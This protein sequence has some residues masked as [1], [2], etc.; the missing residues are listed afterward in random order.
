MN[1]TMQ[2]VHITQSNWNSVLQRINRPDIDHH[3]L[4]LHDLTSILS[5]P[6]LKLL[7]LAKESFKNENFFTD[8]HIRTKHSIDTKTFAFEG[9]CPAYHSSATCPKLSANYSNLLIPVEVK[10]KGDSEIRKFRHF[11][12]E[13]RY[14]IDTDESLFLT[15]LEAQFFLKNPIKKV[16]HNNSGSLETNNLDLDTVKKKIDMLLRDAEKFRS[17]D[18]GTRETIE[19]LGYGTHRRAEAKMRGHV[20]YIWH[21]E[22]KRNLKIYLQTYFRIRFNP[23]LV[24][25]GDLLGEL[26]FQPCSYCHS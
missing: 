7:A 8:K 15:R 22:Y 3:N 16:H 11:C 6:E 10:E 18:K 21:N 1:N 14:L 23:E 26:G 12:K 13:N 2:V 25:R 17:R 24:F 5:I 9:G 19:K 20:L 4:Y